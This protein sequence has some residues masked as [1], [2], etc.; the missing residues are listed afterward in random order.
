MIPII[1]LRTVRT[2]QKLKKVEVKQTNRITASYSK[3]TLY[4]IYMPK[5][6]P[7]QI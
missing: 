7:M 4:N 3:N 2:P 5:M 6:G 1:L